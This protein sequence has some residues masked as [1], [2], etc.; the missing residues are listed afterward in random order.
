MSMNEEYTFE[1]LAPHSR[2]FAALPQGERVAKIKGDRWIGYSRATVAVEKLEG[3]LVHPKK[4]RMPNLL[5]VG[6]TNNGK[7]MIVER[8]HRMHKRKDGANGIAE[9]PVLAMQMPSDPTIA[10]FYAMLLYKLEAPV[11]MRNKVADLEYLSMDLLRKVGIRMLIIDEIHNILAGRSNVQREFLNLIR[12]LGNE[13]RI[14][15][16]GVGT[17][18]AYLAIRSDDQLENRFEPFILPRWE[19][20]SEYK[21][22]LASLSST[23]PLQKPS[24]LLNGDVRTYIL[25]RTEGTIGEISTLICRAAVAA[26][27]TGNESIDLSILEATDYDSPTDRR[28]QFE[29]QLA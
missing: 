13:L 1:H 22:L 2:P 27:E 19:D 29:R 11:S 9:I 14:P 25:R 6:P 20:D 23:I 3:L 15:I 4:E 18:E 10:R 8:F 28:R 16:V 5:I 7:T 12:C 24:S 21:K 26:I 17:K